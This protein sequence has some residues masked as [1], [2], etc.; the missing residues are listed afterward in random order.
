MQ[1][2][3]G[4]PVTV[5][6]GAEVQLEGGSGAGNVHIQLGLIAVGIQQHYLVAIQQGGGNGEVGLAGVLCQ[7]GIKLEAD[8]DNLFAVF[9]LALTEQQV[10]LGCPA[11][12]GLAE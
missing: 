12:D 4:N 3:N 9:Q 1:H 5:Y 7:T 8:A 10:A 6:H 2:P 11:G